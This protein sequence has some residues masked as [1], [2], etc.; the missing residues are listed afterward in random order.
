MK[1]AIL[2]LSAIV[3][4]F[5]VAPA[6]ACGVCDED[7]VA[8]TYDH[9]IV[10]RAA[11]KGRVVVYCAVRG[12]LDAKRLRLAARQVK[13]LDLRS[14]RTSQQP[15]AVSFALDG[16]GQTPQAAVSALQANL[17]QGTE[18]AI[19]GLNGAPSR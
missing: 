16:A 5:A 15:A 18:L 2:L 3:S 8:A 19:V 10:Q 6:R 12:P 4:A 11:S 1:T 9:T 7:K 17:P 14:L 13:G